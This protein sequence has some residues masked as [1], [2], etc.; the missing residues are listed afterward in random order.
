M[1]RA[2]KGQNTVGRTPTVEYLTS[3]IVPIRSTLCDYLVVM[4]IVACKTYIFWCFCLPCEPC[5]VFFGQP[6]EREQQRER[7]QQQQEQFVLG[8]PHQEIQGNVSSYYS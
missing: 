8:R 2:D 1:V 5:G 6:V 4:L 7:E 3:D